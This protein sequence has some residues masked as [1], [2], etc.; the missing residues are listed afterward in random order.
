MSLPRLIAFD[1]D[2]TLAESKS[3]ITSDMAGLLAG[4]ID[5]RPVCVISGGQFS[6]FQTQ[7]LDRLPVTTRW[8]RLHLM[9]TCGTRYLRH[10][11]QRWRQVYAH[12]LP[13]ELRARAAA[14]LERRARELRLWEPDAVVRGERIEDRGSQ[15]TFSALGQQAAPA[16]KRAWDPG[17]D[18]R[19][20]LRA[21]VA[22]DLPELSVRAGG[23]TSIDIT[24]A[25]ID[26]GFGLRHLAQETGIPLGDM[27]FFGDRCDPGGNDYPVVE[28]GV[29]VR[30][31]T[32][33]DDTARQ[34]RVL[35]PA[36]RDTHPDPAKETT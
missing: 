5:V 15:I 11:G 28:L 32:G 27:L 34:I 20:A 9:P 23:S 1:L 13:A 12:D 26:K 22:D 16:D 36:L 6:Q 29:P 14:S 19:L 17:G 4:L 7:V 21:A 30:A 18:K 25:G 33:P 10:D 2:D 31:V 8:A 3:P 24:E 35:L